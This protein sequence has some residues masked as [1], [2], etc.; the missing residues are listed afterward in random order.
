MEAHCEYVTL[1]EVII[2][3]EFY[4]LPVINNRDVMDRVESFEKVVRVDRRTSDESQKIKL[5]AQQMVHK[6]EQDWI[7]RIPEEIKSNWQLLRAFFVETY[8]QKLTEEQWTCLND[9]WKQGANDDPKEFLS[10]CF[11][12]QIYEDMDLRLF[13]EAEDF[14]QKRFESIKRR[15]LNGLNQECRVFYQDVV[16]RAA[17]LH[18]LSR[19][20][21]CEE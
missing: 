2:H 12:V 18:Q 1:E 14:K 13:P 19:M 21:S 9:Q 11:A 17:T 4:T 10:K 6:D 5:F 16:S 3:E 7:S 8:C 20:F 15:F